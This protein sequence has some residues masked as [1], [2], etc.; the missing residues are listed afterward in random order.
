[1]KKTLK[2]CGAIVLFALFVCMSVAC[3]GKSGGGKSASSGGGKSINNIDELKTYLDKQPAN[4]PDKPIKIAMKANEVMLG[5][6]AKALDEAGKYVSL[7]LTGSPMT[8]IPNEVF[9]KCKSLVG[10]TIP[11]SVTSIGQ[12]AFENCSNLASV[13]IQ[14]SVISI[15]DWAFENCS[16]LASITIPDSVKSIGYEAFKGCT[17]LASVTIGNSV[18]SIGEE[19]FSNCTSLANITISNSVTSF[20]ENAFRN[21]SSLTSITLLNSVKSI[22]Y[23]AFNGCTS[24]TSVTFQ[25]TIPPSNFNSYAFVG[26]LYDNFYAT[27]KANGTPGTYTTTAPVNYYSTWTRQ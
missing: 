4:S 26:D 8:T 7:D 23:K 3:S 10:I 1:M 16:N 13:T 19:T 9:N 12:E 20:G 22:Y 25:S 21:C 6:I 11:N 5:N 24:L 2:V 18:T 15:G 14:D 17:S 27:D